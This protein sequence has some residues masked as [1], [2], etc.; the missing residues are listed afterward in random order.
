MN[1]TGP[2]TAAAP[3]PLR[4]G[5]GTRRL[6]ATGVVRF[7]R[8]SWTGALA[9][10]FLLLLV[11]VA[12]LAPQLAPYDPLAANYGAAKMGPTPA[13]PLGT[14]DLGRDVLSRL[15]HG[16]RITLLVAVASVALGDTL[17][18]VWGVLSGYIGGRTDLLGQ[19]VLD[20]LMAFPSLILALLLLVGLGAGLHTVI[21]AIAITRVPMSTRLVRSV[22]LACKETPYIDAA[23]SLGASPL[24]IMARHVAPQCVAPFLI[25]A[26]AHLGVAIF[27]EAALS[28]LGLGVPAPQPS[29]GNMLGGVLAQ[30]FRPPWWL[31]VFPGIAVTLT[32]LA[33]N[34][35]GDGLRDFLDPRLRVRPE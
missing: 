12:V 16:T 8:S 22:V 11:A 29:W 2:I 30:A 31:A 35:L 19:R 27:T 23:R 28:F 5:T 13:H 17:G 14:D 25:V 26:S 34:L 20:A 32:I 9:G 21:L 6:A 1:A 10:V 18:F 4:A 15:I 24:R 3:R 7:V 33:T